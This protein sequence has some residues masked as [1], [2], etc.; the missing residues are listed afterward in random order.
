[1]NVDLLREIQAAAT[2]TKEPVSNLLR[3][4]LILA[5]RL[6]NTTLKCWAESELNGYSDEEP[7]P[8]YRQLGLE[9]KGNF[10]GMFGSS[11]SNFV[12][13]PSR[14]PELVRQAASSCDIRQPIKS[15]ESLLDSDSTS[16]RTSGQ[17]LPLVLEDV[18][19]NMN[20]VAAWYDLPRNS[21]EALVDGVRNRIL[22]LS[23]DLE[24][25]H[26]SEKL[27]GTYMNAKLYGATDPGNRPRSA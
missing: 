18:I 8:R 5:R 4:C 19:V 12:V 10:V 15:L 25:D 27:Q 7:L 14:L 16:F 13:P 20:C 6:N 17:D 1:M 11:A 2:D 9:V 22:E 21:V 3:R 26:T 23:L 24:G